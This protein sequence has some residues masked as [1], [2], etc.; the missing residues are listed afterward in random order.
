MPGKYFLKFHKMKTLLPL[1]YNVLGQLQNSMKDK[2]AEDDEAV[3]T[4]V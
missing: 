4:T 3:Q 1:D 2:Y